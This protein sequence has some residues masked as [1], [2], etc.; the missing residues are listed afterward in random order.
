MIWELLLLFIGLG[1]IFLYLGI[2]TDANKILIATAA[3]L[4]LIASINLYI[5]G[6]DIEEGKDFVYSNNFTENSIHWDT[7]DPNPNAFTNDAF[8][9]HEQHTHTNY[10]NI[11]IQGL[12]T[13]LLALSC[14]LYFFIFIP[15]GQ[16]H[17]FN[18]Y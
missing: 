17:N 18:N 10:N 8:I 4:F 2:K 11:Y 5:E 9:V 3:T 6:I 13:L 1:A 16:K 15:T 14:A 7:E 12:A